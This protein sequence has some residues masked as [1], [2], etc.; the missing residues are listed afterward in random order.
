MSNHSDRL[1]AA[2]ADA[3]RRHPTF[4]DAL[5]SIGTILAEELLE[6][7]TAGMAAL[8]AINDH[9]DDGRPLEDVLTELRHVDVVV[10]RALERL[11]GEKV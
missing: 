10:R 8:Q 5:D 6:V 1:T 9:R 2:Y 7:T 3:C 4:P 11:E